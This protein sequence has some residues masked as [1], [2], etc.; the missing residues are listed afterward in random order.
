MDKFNFS[1]NLQW[2]KIILLFE[3]RR[4]SVTFN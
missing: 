1:L 2:K 3:I 4:K